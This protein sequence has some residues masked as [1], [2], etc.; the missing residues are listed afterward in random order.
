MKLSALEAEFRGRAQKAF[1]LDENQAASFGFCE[2]PPHIHSDTST[3]WPI[4]AAKQLKKPPLQ[5]AEELKAAFEPQYKVEIVKPGFLN[6]KFDDK[7][8]FD[9]L[10][11]IV[12]VPDCFKDPKLGVRKINI[13][14]VS[15]NPTGPLHLASGRGATLGDS[16]ARIMR[17]LGAGVTSEYYVNNMGRQV[18]LLGRS[19]KARFEGKEPPEDGYKGAYLKELAAGLPPEASGWTEKQFS[20]FA[21]AR[22]L[23]LHRADMKAFGVQFDRW[24][25]ESELHE[26][27]APRKALQALKDLGVT[28][29][30]EGAVWFGADGTPQLH[31]SDDKDRVLVK[32]DGR[33]TYFLNDIAYHLNK[34]D[35]GFNSLIDIWG[36]DHHGYVPRMEAAVSVLGKGRGGFKVIIHQMVILKRGEE[37]VKMSKR[38]GDFVSLKELVEEGGADACRFFFATR[39]PNTHLV[40]DIDL[41]KKRSN[42]NPVY[43]VQ[44]VHARICSIFANA[45][46]KGVDVKADFNPAETTFNPEERALALKLL[47]FER[48]LKTCADDFSPHYLTTYLTELSALFHSFYTKHKVL[49]PERPQVTATRLFLLKAV[50]TVISD[51]LTLLGVS[52]PEKM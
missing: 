34:Y 8:L 11:E 7:F 39:G 25:M 50:K 30:K 44:Y 41:A 48:T 13:E 46:E 31:G 5:I 18:E 12:S 23:E 52:S 32:S 42:E 49:D 6:I 29:E 16:L 40:F 2:P 4:S 37:L 14:F 33:N 22:M 45:A 19:L 43:Y 10:R 3:S 1:S 47:W 15:A 38:E 51:G 35:R 26:A 9:A 27:G 28:Q 21:V 20:E 36:A 24:F 17:F